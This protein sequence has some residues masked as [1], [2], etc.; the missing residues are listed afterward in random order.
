MFRWRNMPLQIHDGTIAIMPNCLLI[1]GR[2]R[3][4]FTAENFRVD[5]HDQHLLVVGSV[6]DADPPALRQIRVVRQRKSCSNSVALGCL[7][8]NTWQP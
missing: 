1:V 3:Q 5:A 8:L 6:E 2:V 4:S 7:K